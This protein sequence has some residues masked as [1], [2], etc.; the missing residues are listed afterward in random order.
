[1]T[2][3]IVTTDGRIHILED[4]THVWNPSVKESRMNAMDLFAHGVVQIDYKQGELQ[5]LIRASTI[6]SFEISTY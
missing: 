1:M 4:V 3:R 6:R 5:L 2:V